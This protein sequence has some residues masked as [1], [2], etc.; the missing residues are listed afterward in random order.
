[1]YISMIGIIKAKDKNKSI[2]INRKSNFYT[3]TC[4]HTHLEDNFR[5]KVW[6]CE[7]A[8]AR[9]YNSSWI[10]ATSVHKQLCKDAVGSLWHS[11]QRQR[12]NKKNTERSVRT[13]KERGWKEVRV[14]HPWWEWR[15]SPKLPQKFQWPQDLRSLI[16]VTGKCWRA[17]R[18]QTCLGKG[19]WRDLSIKLTGSGSGVTW[20]TREALW[21][22]GT[23]GE[24]LGSNP[25]SIFTTC[26]TRLK[27]PNLS[28]PQFPHMQK[29]DSI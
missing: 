3:H 15:G 4:T 17:S 26:P 6:V 7:I 16:F 25:R 24:S 28:V 27:L 22:H 23:L 5:T 10:Q 8:Q 20:P 2:H 21:H 11:Y 12:R 29:R 19:S 14:R 9:V 13:K 18:K 1:M